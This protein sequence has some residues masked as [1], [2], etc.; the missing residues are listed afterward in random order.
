MGESMRIKTRKKCIKCDMKF[1]YEASQCFWN[2]KGTESTKLIKCPECGCVQAIDYV[3]V[4][5][6]NND[7]RFYE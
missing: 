7:K 1:F 5:N 4:K 2:E 6:P 3:L